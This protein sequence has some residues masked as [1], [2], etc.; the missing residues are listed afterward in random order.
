MS[1]PICLALCFVSVLVGGLLGVLYTC[2]VTAAAAR[3]RAAAR[4]EDPC[5]EA[6]FAERGHDA[7]YREGC[8]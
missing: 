7:V 4:H 2:I 1:I 8:L 3:D 6:E 5:V